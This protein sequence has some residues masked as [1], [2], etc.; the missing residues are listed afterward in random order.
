MQ[1]YN[2]DI[3]TQFVFPEEYGLVEDV[4]AVDIKPRFQLIETEESLRLVGIYHITSTVRFDPH[5]LPEYSE[6]T[7]IEHIELNEDDGYF[8]YALPLEVN[9]PKEKIPDGC[10]PELYVENVNYDVSTGSCAAFNWDVSCIIP[11]PV[12]EPAIEEED[13]IRFDAYLESNNIPLEIPS[14]NAFA[15]LI[16]NTETDKLEVSPVNEEPVSDEEPVSNE[17]E[18]VLKDDTIDEV[19]FDNSSYVESFENNSEESINDFKPET[20]LQSSNVIV[21]E[22]EI[23]VSEVEQAS[24]ELEN[25]ELDL[26]DGNLVQ[27]EDLSPEEEVVDR[28]FDSD[29]FFSSLSESY[30][31]LD[32]KSNKVSQEEPSDYE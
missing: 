13:S 19:S 8:E 15:D 32:L 31:L 30:T 2:W 17:E 22:P 3:K 11:E 20:F 21:P 9:L 29:D 6:G 5:E 24:N 1:N 7:L 10:H 27:T 18:L 25:N 12:V 4:V 28:A 14:A 16:Q 23:V 26:V